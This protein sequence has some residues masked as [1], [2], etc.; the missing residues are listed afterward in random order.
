MSSSELAA[1]LELGD[2]S[3]SW[4]GRDLTSTDCGARERGLHPSRAPEALGHDHRRSDVRMS[5]AR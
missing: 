4:D 5:D 2:R 3:S 1:A